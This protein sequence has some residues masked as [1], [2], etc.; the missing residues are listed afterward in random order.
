VA[1]IITLLLAL[2]IGSRL[3]VYDVI[4]KR[5]A[6]L[7]ERAQANVANDRVVLVFNLFDEL[8]RLLPVKK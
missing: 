8:N 1:C 4:A 3:G 7:A 2:T 6:V 5:L